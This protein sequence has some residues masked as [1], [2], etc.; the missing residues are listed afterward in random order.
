MDP[1]TGLAYGRIAV[2]T[3]SLLSPKLAARLFLLDPATNPQL[4]YMGRLFGSREIA[5]GLVTLAAPD[6]EARRRLIQV[7]VGVDAADAFNGIVSAAS[8]STSKRAGLLLTVAGVAST[9]T[10]VLALQES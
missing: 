7:G 9:A 8:G 6:G 4:P 3:L 10:G 1:I 5:L 2:G